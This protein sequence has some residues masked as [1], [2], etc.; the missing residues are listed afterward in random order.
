MSNAAHLERA[1]TRPRSATS[2]PDGQAASGVSRTAAWRLNNDR[3]GRPESDVVGIALLSSVVR[4]KPDATMVDVVHG[5]IEDLVQR[6]FDREEVHGVFRRWRRR[7]RK[8]S[9]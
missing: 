6:G 5:A 7:M 1:A 4:Q 3:R 8:K 2:D 9:S